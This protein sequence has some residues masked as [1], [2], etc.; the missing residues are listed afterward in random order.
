MRVRLSRTL[1]CLCSQSVKDPL[2]SRK[3]PSAGAADR[4]RAG[5]FTAAL[6]KSECKGT[7]FPR[8][9][10][11]FRGFFFMRG[12]FL[13]V[14]GIRRAGTGAYTLFIYIIGEDFPRRSSDGAAGELRRPSGTA[15]PPGRHNCAAEAGKLCYQSGKAVPGWGA[16]H[17][18]VTGLSHH[19]KIQ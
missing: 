2:A 16:C 10:Q 3:P 14:F 13:R 6:P 11:A 12:R 7:H 1:R 19:L 9:T 8:N 15:L 5:A 18:P 4:A 17:R